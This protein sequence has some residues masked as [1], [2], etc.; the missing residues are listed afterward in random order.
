MIYNL[1]NLHAII[2]IIIIYWSD[3]YFFNSQFQQLQEQVMVDVYFYNLLKNFS[4]VSHYLI[5]ALWGWGCCASLV[6]EQEITVL[7]IVL[8]ISSIYCL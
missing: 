8:T 3:L 2:Y 4:R 5:N 1:K 7:L 6:G